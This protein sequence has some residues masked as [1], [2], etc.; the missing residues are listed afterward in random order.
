MN[1]LIEAALTVL[2]CNQKE[3]AQRLNVSQTQISKSKSDEYMSEDYRVK[4]SQL[5]GL[6]ETDLSL[7]LEVK[8]PVAAV[9]L[10]E[11]IA[12]LID[13]ADEESESPYSVESHSDYAS[14]MLPSMIVNALSKMKVSMPYPLVDEISAIHTLMLNDEADGYE[15]FLEKVKCSRFFFMV[16]KIAEHFANLCAF[17]VA[18][19]YPLDE[20]LVGYEENVW[21]VEA[22]LLQLSVA[23]ACDEI[24]ILYYRMN[25]QSVQKS[26]KKEL[27]LLKHE[28]EQRN[29]RIPVD[30]LELVLN[31]D[32]VMLCRKAEREALGFND[33]VMPSMSEPVLP[34]DSIS[35]PG[36][37][38]AI[39]NHLGLNVKDAIGVKQ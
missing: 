24:E 30:I 20:S 18:Y 31:E 39:Y 36:M 5:T 1:L 33:D 12:K 2:N 8:C 26:L 3:L 29:I 21:A 15:T 28:A 17:Y 35:V 10:K 14:G 16:S 6:E 23:I 7:F 19:I 38:T 27:L 34:N 13:L 11:V 4:L 37:I 25:K 9:K 22:E 32:T